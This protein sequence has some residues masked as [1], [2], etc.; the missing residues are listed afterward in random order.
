M[1]GCGCEYLRDSCQIK[2]KVGC[3]AS[4]LYTTKPLLLIVEEHINDDRQGQCKH[5]PLDSKLTCN[6]EGQGEEIEAVVAMR[7]TL[8]K[9]RARPNGQRGGGS[10]KPRQREAVFKGPLFNITAGRGIHNQHTFAQS[11]GRPSL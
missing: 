9:H 5:R 1:Q 2:T 6:R 10:F 11:R 3:N 8:E 4:A 7:A